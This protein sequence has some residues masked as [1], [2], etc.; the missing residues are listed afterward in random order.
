MK[1]ILSLVFVLA[2]LCGSYSSLS[3]QTIGDVDIDIELGD[4]LGG[5]IPHRAPA[6]IP[7]DAKYVCII[8]SVVFTFADNIGTVIIS[9]CNTSTGDYTVTNL[10]T[11]ICSQEFVPISGDEGYIGHILTLMMTTIP[12]RDVL[13][14]INKC[15]QRSL[16]KMHQHKKY[17]I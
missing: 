6:L 13:L 11:D 3:A 4:S 16:L 14:R 10:N 2:F 1:R 5:A 12:I 15:M 9:I 17:I 8:S 7:F